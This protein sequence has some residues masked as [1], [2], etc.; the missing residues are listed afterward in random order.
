MI[1][2][3]GSN[4]RLFV[5]ALARG[6]A[7]LAAF[8]PGEGSLSNLQLARRTGLPKSTVSRLS[9][10]LQQLGYLVQESDS[11]AWRPGPAA[12]T[13]ASTLQGNFDLRRTLLPLMQQFSR[14][15]G[16]ASTLGI[17][18]AT[19][20][21]YLETCRSEAKVSVQLSEGSRVP[22]ATT[23][24]G[25]ACY[26]TL[27]MITRTRLD[28]LLADRY[29]QQWPQIAQGLNQAIEEY[30]RLGF[31]TSFGEFAPTVMAVGVSLA[32]ANS[33]Q[34]VLCMNASGPAFVFDQQSML[35]T[36]GPALLAL[37]NV[38]APVI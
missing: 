5:T 25:R 10:T 13:L 38:V 4:D 19:D 34:A 8:Q 31:C 11:G 21:V 37:R 22:L 28:A 24:I 7:L 30:A 6:L 36:I 16:I 12:L 33:R 35:Q 14:Q 17:L 18:E 29:Q 3:M 27:D 1:E 9:H 32:G 15:Y 26:A 2:K 23:A 20:I